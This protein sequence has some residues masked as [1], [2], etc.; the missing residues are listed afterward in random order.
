[1]STKPLFPELGLDDI[2][3]DFDLPATCGENV[4]LSALRGR[5]V[6]LFFYPQDGSQ[7]CTA[8][9]VAFSEAAP[10]FEAA[11]AVVFGISPDS[12]RR[13]E[14]FKA[15]NGLAID[16]ISD[17]KR[18]AIDAYGLWIE[19]TTFGHVHMGVDRSTFLIGPD[20]RIAAI[21]RRVRLKGHVE[22]VIQHL[23]L[24]LSRQTG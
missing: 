22:E 1:M 20:R 13:H 12:I 18:S 19:K 11:G 4:R 7:T 15:R 14:N 5:P 9:A 23:N 6:V 3:P 17:E 21:W 8:E 24:L 2:A 10:R 16:L